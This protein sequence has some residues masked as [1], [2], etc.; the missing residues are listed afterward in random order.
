MF[1][2]VYVLLSV[3]GWLWMLSVMRCPSPLSVQSTSHS[4]SNTLTPTRSRDQRWVLSRGERER[5]HLPP[6][7]LHP[8]PCLATS[9]PPLGLECILTALRHIFSGTATTMPP[10]YSAT[11][12]FIAESP[13]PPASEMFPAV[14]K[15]G[16]HHGSKKQSGQE[17][18][19]WSSFFPSQQCDT[20]EG[21]PRSQN[22][23]S[24]VH[25]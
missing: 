2:F 13:F 21:I 11:L 19:D 24:D 22:P 18:P 16:G 7:L 12:C 25:D 4:K 3:A 8:P 5:P 17:F 20:F 23:S 9:N 15:R 10:P 1:V 14:S 6:S